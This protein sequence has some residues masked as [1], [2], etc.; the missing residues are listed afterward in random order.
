MTYFFKYKFAALATVLALHT[1]AQAQPGK[2]QTIEINSSYKPILRNAVKINFNGTQAAADTSR[3]Q[4]KYTIPAQ[5]LVYSYNPVP[6]NALSIQKDDSLQL[7]NRYYAKLGFG[8]LSTPYANV[9]A[10]FGDGKKAIVNAYASYIQSKGALP[11]QKFS[12]LNIKLAGS[13]FREKSELYGSISA[14]LRT[15][16]FYGY[17]KALYINVQPSFLEQKYTT[18]GINVGY[19][20]T[21]VNDAG[22]NYN[23]TLA[24]NL[25]QINERL[26]ETNL[27]IN[28][29]FW[30]DI[31]DN[32]TGKINVNADI[33]SGSTVGVTPSNTTYTNNVINITPQVKFSNDNMQIDGG[34]QLVWINK[35]YEILPAVT[36]EFPIQG[37][38]FLV[39]AG[40]VGR[41]IKNNM[42]NLAQQNEF[43]AAS[44]FAQP[45]TKE[46]ELY[47]GIKASFAKH[48][49]FS[50][51]AGFVNYNNMPFWVN[52]TLGVLFN[53]KT[54]NEPTA[55]NI[56]VHADLSYINQ[57]KFSF[58]TAFNFNGFTNLKVNQRAW[59]VY[60]VELKGSLRWWALKSILLK[61]D[62]WLFD[63][64]NYL[65]FNKEAKTLGG[66]ADLSLG[67]EFK[68]NKQIS[69]WGQANNL[70]NSRYQRWNQ[71][72]VYGANFLGGVLVKF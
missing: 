51:K 68:L 67:I 53:F 8:N 35:K 50:A 5:N 59:H 57:D 14:D 24:I 45:N 55:S 62:A 13:N 39:Q 25:F 31:N 2:P 21:V 40:W 54:S 34:V 27:A 20:N 23:P 70:L 61:A 60:P 36:A 42:Q 47:G 65:W 56:R 19:R 6:L 48:F 52:D 11:F 46:M 12:N 1:Q 44:N 64:A 38:K 3:P 71:Y 72:P 43:L 9:G 4:L 37:K 15:R 22:I 7:G 41:I 49:N 63:G 28:A 10:S 69:L 58:T 16:N 29:P 33:T 66:G 26:R 17:N 18:V 32:F 30:K